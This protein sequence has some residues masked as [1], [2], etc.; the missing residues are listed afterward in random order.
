MQTEE[1]K[2]KAPLHWRILKWAVLFFA[3]YTFIF[4]YVVPR[5]A[6]QIS[7]QK[8]SGLLKREVIIKNIS[9]NPYDLTINI[10]GVSI[11]DTEKQETLLAWN[12]LYLNIQAASLF[13]GGLILKE[14]LLSRPYINVVRYDDNSYNLPDLPEGSA[15]EP[16]PESKPFSFSVNNIQISGGSIDFNDSPKNTKHEARDITL[17][18]PMFSSFPYH[19]DNYVQPLFRATFNGTPVL[20]EGKTKPFH[21][22]LKTI[23]DL[24]L[25]GINIPYYLEYVPFKMNFKVLSGTI[26]AKNTITFT[27]YMDKPYSVTLEGDIDFRKIEIVDTS[28]AQ[29]INLPEISIS[30]APSELIAGNISLSRFIIQSPTINI[31]KDRAGTINLESLVPVKTEDKPDE[32]SEESTGSFEVESSEFII[33]DGKIFFSDE[34]LEKTVKLGLENLEIKA[35]N[36]STKKDS[37]GNISVAAELNRSGAISVSGPVGINPLFADLNFDLNNISIVPLQPYFTD[38]VNI[39][40]TNGGFSTNG[41]L[42]LNYKNDKKLNAGFSGDVSLS[43]FAS[44]DK[45]GADDFLSWD[46]LYI[47]G[48]NVSYSP[49]KISI[50]DVALT[51]FYSR[52]IINSDNSLNVQ[53][54]VKEEKAEEDQEPDSSAEKQESSEV[55]QESSPVTRVKI[56]TITLQAGTVNFSDNHIKPN[57]AANLL[58]IGGRVSGLSSDGGTTA[59]VD[60]RGKL[61]NHAPLEITGSINPLGKD[62]FADIKV[63]FHDMDLS[64]LTPYSGTYLGRTIQKGKLSLAL[65]YR[66][67]KRKLDAENKVLL[68]QFALGSKVDSPDATKLPVGLAIALLKDSKGEIN[69]DLPVTGSID[70]PKFSIGKVVLKLIMNIFIKAATSPFA[71]LGALVGGGEELSY[72]DFEYG[73]SSIN[74]PEEAKLDKLIKALSARPGLKLEI[75]GYVNAEQDMEALRQNAFNKKINSQK[76]KDLLKSGQETVPVDE[77]VVGPD[78]YEEYLRKAYKEEKFPKPRNALGLVKKLPVPEM[79][80]LIFAHIK[81][82]DDDLRL[83]AQQ[84]AQKVKDYILN[85]GQIDGKR[86][87]LIEPETLQPEKK[88]KMK[89]SRIDFKLK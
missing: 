65:K 3:F 11:M 17:K 31:K 54:I 28:D 9:F 83:L 66:I 58:E 20:V 27:Q 67:D 45:A 1:K 69:L 81:L 43:K 36:I 53:G 79:E 52:L 12:N 6:E 22:S 64:P 89:L 88:G 16:G 30:V 51:D 4:S 77:I 2:I 50:N 40:V 44:V 29:M 62:L 80:K 38:R 74:E 32:A 5:V 75:S 85:T 18:I 49:L 35:E 37:G 7:S 34:S 60:L 72:I 21:D 73:L 14:V 48:I 42:S 76:L 61:E 13:K 70:D 25:E 82:N 33:A 10:S 24:N 19:I 47:S 56:N 71:L 68:D 84:R 87:F 23:I 41:N 78:E 63:D 39:L 15:E 8:L 46:S 26:N 57:F 55:T 59:D 86:V